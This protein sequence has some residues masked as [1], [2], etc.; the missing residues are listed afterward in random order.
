MQTLLRAADFNRWR[1]F[2]KA[3]YSPTNRHSSRCSYCKARK[4]HSLQQHQTS[5]EF[6]AALRKDE[7]RIMQGRGIGPC[8]VVYSIR[9]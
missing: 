6:T 9:K 4:K 3:F 7:K 5:M 1:I 2:M 8:I